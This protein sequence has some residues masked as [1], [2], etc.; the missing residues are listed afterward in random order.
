MVLFGNVH[1]DCLFM[2]HQTVLHG[3]V[4]TDGNLSAR[5]NYMWTPNFVTKVQAQVRK[6]VENSYIIVFD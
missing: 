1:T 5:A 2:H 4:D 6:N 3:T